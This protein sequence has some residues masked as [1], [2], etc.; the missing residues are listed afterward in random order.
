MESYTD[1]YYMERCLQLAC[2]GLGNTY[3]NPAVG[4]VI[5][6]KGQIIGE[7]F[8]TK[9]GS[10]HAEA[11]A[12]NQVQNKELL[13]AATMYV[14]LE[15]CTH[16]GK[17]P[18]C[19]DLI[20]GMGIPRVVIGTSDPNKDISGRGIQRMRDAG[21]EVI[22]GILGEKSLWIN[23]R[24][25][26][27]HKEQRPYIILKWAQT[28]DGFIDKIR[29]PDEPIRP[30]WITNEI[31]R[32]AVHKWRGTEQAIMVGTSTAIKDNPKLN[33]RDWHGENP[34]RIV[35]DRE[36]K[37]SGDLSLFDGT[38]QTLV[39]TEYASKTMS[40]GERVQV[41]FNQGKAH[42]VQQILGELYRRDIH[43]LF[44][45]GGAFLLNIFIETNLWDE[46]RVFIGNTFFNNGKKAPVL[47]DGTLISEEYFG[48]S[49]LFVYRNA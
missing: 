4:A 38:I 31:A 32:V 1:R 37:L 44:V 18:P 23:R 19:A 48:H 26:T 24:F 10:P 34:L 17:T 16:Y 29:T 47:K 35:I 49:R 22:T 9:A 3:P 46:A 25:F 15:P 5:V 2:R 42:V 6:Y 7:G 28:L 27:Y 13:K 45:E 30:I 12:V 21:I 11:N 33:M 20:I 41:D 39:F 36:L 43:S 14:N 8:H 40:Y